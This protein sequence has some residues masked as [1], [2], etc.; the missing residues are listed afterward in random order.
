MC[1]LV[2]DEGKIMVRGFRA[3]TNA[4]DAHRSDEQLTSAQALIYLNSGSFH[5]SCQTITPH[6]V[7]CVIVAYSKIT[8][9]NSSFS[10]FKTPFATTMKGGHSVGAAIITH[11]R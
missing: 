8:N 2:D 1:S 3:G 10:F 6:L 5:A 7:S 9:Q 4:S 11:V